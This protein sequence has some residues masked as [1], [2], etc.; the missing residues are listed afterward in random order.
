M[1]FCMFKK[2]FNKSIQLYCLIVGDNVLLKSI[3]CANKIKIW[4][5]I[6]FCNL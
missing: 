2:Y 4:G 6:F 3:K 5:L 1:N